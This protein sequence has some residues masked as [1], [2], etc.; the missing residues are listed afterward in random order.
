MTLIPATKE[1]PMCSELMQRRERET[2]VRVPGTAE[3][4]T[5][6]AIEWVCPECDYF[7]DAGESD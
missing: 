4:K 2:V 7:E 1:C 3:T 6:A 5:L